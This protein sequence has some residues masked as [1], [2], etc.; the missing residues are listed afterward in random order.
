MLDPASLSRTMM[1]AARESLEKYHVTVLFVIQ[2]T[3]LSDS[4]RD[5][6]QV[7]LSL[8]TLL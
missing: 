7:R 4:R 8:E 3:A 6:H 2:L 5:L 1:K